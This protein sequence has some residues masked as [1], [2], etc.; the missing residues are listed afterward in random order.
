[1]SFC[2][3]YMFNLITIQLQVKIWDFTTDFFKTIK[4]KLKLRNLILTHFIR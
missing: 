1:M 3:L 4:I 2:N